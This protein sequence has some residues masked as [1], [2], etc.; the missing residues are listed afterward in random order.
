ME[1]FGESTSGMGSGAAVSLISR[2][3]N[4]NCLWVAEAVLNILSTID[5]KPGSRDVQ[6]D[7]TPQ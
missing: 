5:R 2:G 1:T 4:L 6:I 7:T 3:T